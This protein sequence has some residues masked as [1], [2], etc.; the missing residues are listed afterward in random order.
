[1]W[2]TRVQSEG[3][4][5]RGQVLP[6]VALMMLVVAGVAVAVVMVGSVLVDRATARTAADAT[7]LAAA[8]DGDDA[9]R[10]VARANGAAVVRIEREGDA[11]EVEVE[12][13]RARAR[14]RATA[15]R[16]V[17]PPGRAPPARDGAAA[18]RK[19]DDDV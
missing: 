16:E 10:R 1:M 5:E 14:A 4:A 13:G 12:V 17:V 15:V 2:H 18:G 6:L 11:V 3:R 8:L 19:L 9:A 7:A